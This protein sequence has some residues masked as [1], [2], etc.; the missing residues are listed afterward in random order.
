MRFKD[1]SGQKR[2]CAGGKNNAN[3]RSRS[4]VSRR[5]VVCHLTRPAG[6]QARKSR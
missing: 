5:P 4:P 3:R 6:R 1:V 2:G